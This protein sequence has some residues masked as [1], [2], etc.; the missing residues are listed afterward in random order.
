M[1]GQKCGR[2]T[3]AVDAVDARARDD[4]DGGDGN[5]SSAT[6]RGITAGCRAR[7]RRRWRRRREVGGCDSNA[8]DVGR[9]SRRAGVSSSIV[10]GIDDTLR[11]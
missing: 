6:V 2:A 11:H 3:R 7:S 1:G 5:C 8:R 9:A 10:D 4:D